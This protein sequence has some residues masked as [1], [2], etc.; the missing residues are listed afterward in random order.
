MTRRWG[1][2]LLL[3]LLL[4]AG[5]T[6]DAGVESFDPN[7]SGGQ[8][9]TTQNETPTTTGADAQSEN[10]SA[11]PADA[12][13][14]ADANATEDEPGI[15][16]TVATETDIPILEVT[17]TPTDIP[18]TPTAVASPTVLPTTSDA[19]STPAAGFTPGGPSVPEEAQPVST[20]T[21]TLTA[22]PFEGISSGEDTGAA[23][24]TPADDTE[25]VG[26]LDGGGS[27]EDGCTY[28]VQSGDNPFR[29]AVNNNITLDELRAANPSLSG[30]TIIQPGDVLEIPGCGQGASTEDTTPDETTTEDSTTPVPG[31]FIEY[32]VVSGDT[33]GRIANRYGVTIAEIAEANELTNIDQ[34]SIGQV[35]LIPQNG[36]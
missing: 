25:S 29:I 13:T 8:T 34:L 4:I 21:P 1:T 14:D 2:L 22:T 3:L 5:C 11:T 10:L 17:D 7:G 16:I 19:T 18:S 32:T 6:R 30:S 9:D 24:A 33:L 28:T 20:A 27:S 26:N 36:E 15:A 23:T 12:D 35:L 31:D